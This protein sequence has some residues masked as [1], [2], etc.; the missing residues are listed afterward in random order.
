MNRTMVWTRCS[1]SENLFFTSCSAPWRFPVGFSCWE[2]LARDPRV[3]EEKEAGRLVTL[4]HAHTSAHTWFGYISQGSRL[5]RLILSLLSLWAQGQDFTYPEMPY[6]CPWL[7]FFNS[8]LS[9]SFSSL[10]FFSIIFPGV[11]FISCW[12]LDLKV[13]KYWIM[14]LQPK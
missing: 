7:N 3:Q 13:V 5:G 12:D 2:T 6:C 1:T 14:C 11:L 9:V 10:K 8:H 4:P